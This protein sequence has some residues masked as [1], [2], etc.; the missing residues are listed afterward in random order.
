MVRWTYSAAI[1]DES[2]DS[3][4]ASEQLR[5][6]L[7]IEDTGDTMCRGGLRSIGHLELT[8]DEDW[9]KR[10]M[11][12]NVKERIPTRRPKKILDKV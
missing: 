7:G 11:N 3:R 1:T 5:E 4:M 8:E 10:F 12:V 2:A 6:R 9:V